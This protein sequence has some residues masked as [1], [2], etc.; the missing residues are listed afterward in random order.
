MLNP[1]D[2]S[3]HNCF[4]VSFENAT[5]SE[6]V[7]YAEYVKEHAEQQPSLIMVGVDDANFIDHTDAHNLS[8]PVRDNETPYFWQYYFT[9]DVV[10]WSL[11]TIFD[12][13]QRS[14]RPE[15]AYEPYQRGRI[16]EVSSNISQSA[17]C[18]LC[19]T[20]RFGAHKTVSTIG[21]VAALLK[22]ATCHG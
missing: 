17:P 16:C 14:P 11:K 20:D 12:T 10:K 15:A 1:R 19:Y 18:C 6:R 4:V 22:G 21:C 9:V 8:E 5:P 2:F 3:G 13:F 7:A